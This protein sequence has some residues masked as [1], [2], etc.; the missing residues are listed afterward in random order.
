MRPPAHFGRRGTLLAEALDAPGVDELVHLLRPFGDLSVAL[1]AVDHLDTHFLGQ[2]VEG[3]PGN[4]VANDLGVLRLD[5]LVG[6]QALANVD[7][8]LLDEMGDEA[9]VGAV[10]ND[11]G[12]PLGL[13][14][15]QAAAQVHVPPIEGLFRR[16]LPGSGRIGIP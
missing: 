15:G 7:Q 3:L 13:P 16:M 1:A 4:Q 9:R 5:L 8:A 12:R 11:G 2:P 14:G 6:N 10:L